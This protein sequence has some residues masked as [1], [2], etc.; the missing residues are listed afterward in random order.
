MAEFENMELA[1]FLEELVKLMFESRPECVSL[2][3]KLPDGRM[4]T[5]YYNASVSDKVAT[6]G[7]IHADAMLD[8]IFNNAGLLKEAMEEED[9]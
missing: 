2:A 7:Q 8:M 4:F 6:A 9:G 3:A 5:A 1:E